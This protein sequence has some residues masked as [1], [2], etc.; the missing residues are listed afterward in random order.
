MGVALSPSSGAPE[1]VLKAMQRSLNPTEAAGPLAGRLALVTGSTR[2]I[3]R[4]IAERLAGAGAE[5]VVVGRD[6]DKAQAA[7]DEMKA[8]GL[9]AG[10]IGA[11]LEDDAA[12][13]RLIPEVEARFGRLD[14]LVNN[15]GI[16]ADNLLIDHPLED[17]RRIMKVNLEVP[18]RLSQAAAP[19]FF[20]KGR[21]VIINIT[22]ILGLKPG[23]GAAAYVPAKHGLIGLT[24][25]MALEWAPQGVRVNAIA[26]GLIQTDMT[27]YVWDSPIGEAYLKRSLP[28]GRFGRPNDIGALAAFLASDDAEFIHG[29]TIVV[30]GAGLLA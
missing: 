23:Q 10:A 19:H 22:S 3:G 11:D 2:G 9:L 16:D 27:R 14:I 8:A 30:D 17:W 13:E 21:G 18:F 26:P 12:I 15:A 25:Q 5:V 20:E 6:P 4:S 24:K 1:E 28:A 7:A 29:A